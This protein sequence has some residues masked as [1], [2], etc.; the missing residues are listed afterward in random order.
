MI[1]PIGPMPGSGVI[2][3]IVCVCNRI[4]DRDIERHARSGCASF[5]E[6]QLDSGVSSC[7]GRCTDCARDVFETARSSSHRGQAI[8]FA[9]RPVAA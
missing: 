9:A 4:S 3:M 2:K 6:L 5:D 8:N 1:A 7:C